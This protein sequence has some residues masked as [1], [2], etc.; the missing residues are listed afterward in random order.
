MPHSCPT[1]STPDWTLPSLIQTPGS[2]LL[3]TLA[4]IVALVW[5]WRVV[6][7]VAPWRA[8]I[9]VA[10][11]YGLA[12]IMLLA[13]IFILTLVLPPYQDASETQLLYFQ[14]GVSQA[15]TDCAIIFLRSAQFSRNVIIQMSMLCC[16]VALLSG[17]MCAWLRARSSKTQA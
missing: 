1:I 4:A 12:A 7:P 5:A 16:A 10:F 8:R 13:A 14:P 6:A 9:P 11:A 2:W 15:T 17:A 3:L